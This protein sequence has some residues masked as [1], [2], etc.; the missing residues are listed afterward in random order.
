MSHIIT[1]QISMNKPLKMEIA[2]ASSYPLT[3][4]VSI[5]EDDISWH[6]LCVYHGAKVA[7]MVHLSLKVVCWR[8]ISIN[9]MTV[10]HTHVRYPSF[11]ALAGT[12]SQHSC[13][14]GS[15]SRLQVKT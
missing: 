6:L 14:L 5:L 2:D 9:A 4:V 8:N 3:N 1:F 13:T 12:H 7:K 15:P 10:Q 11:V